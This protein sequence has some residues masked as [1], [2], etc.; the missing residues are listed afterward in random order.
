MHR[1]RRR[2]EDQH[3]VG[4]VGQRRLRPGARLQRRPQGGRSPRRLVSPREGRRPHRPRGRRE[5]ARNGTRRDRSRNGGLRRGRQGEGDEQQASGVGLLLRRG[6]E[7]AAG[8]RSRRD[9]L[10]HGHSGV[11]QPQGSPQDHGVGRQLPQQRVSGQDRNRGRAASQGGLERPQ[12][13]RRQ[14]AVHPLQDPGPRRGVR[15]HER[16]HQALANL[17]DDPRRRRGAAAA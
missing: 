3:A 15:G 8:T 1:P 16:L 2:Q 11:Q 14:Q 6:G 12:A 4:C 17:Q 10:R 5:A 13:R 7:Q 9:H